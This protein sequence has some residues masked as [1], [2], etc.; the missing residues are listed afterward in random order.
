MILVFKYYRKSRLGCFRWNFQS[1]LRPKCNQS[2][3]CLGSLRSQTD[4]SP[5]KDSV[6][7][8]ETARDSSITLE[9]LCQSVDSGEMG[10]YLSH[11]PSYFFYFNLQPVTLVLL[12]SN[13]KG[14]LSQ[15]SVRK[16]C[17][18]RCDYLRAQTRLSR[19]LSCQYTDCTGHKSN[20]R[21]CTLKN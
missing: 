13:Q 14:E 17:E 20:A 1:D 7:T 15:W 21:P 19:K 5:S 4:V 10:V 6:S 18:I 8:R 2:T 9:F 12:V 16:S 11:L 3:V